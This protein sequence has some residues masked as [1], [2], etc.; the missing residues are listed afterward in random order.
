MTK[1]SSI[2]A[3]NLWDPINVVISLDI[4]QFKDESFIEIMLPETMQLKIH[5]SGYLTDHSFSE[6]FSMRSHGAQNLSA[7][8]SKAMKF[9]VW[10]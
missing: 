8:D 5:A 9:K 1:Y 3:Q 2:M 10:I 7:S 6:I 4:L